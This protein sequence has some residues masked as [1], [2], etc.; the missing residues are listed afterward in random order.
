MRP[1]LLDTGVIVSWL[2]SSES[3]HTRC[4]AILDSLPTPVFTCDAV[5][6]E[7]CY[8]L[9]RLPGACEAILENIAAGVFQ[10]PFR[11]SDSAR[12]VQRIVRKYQDREIDLADACLIHL[13][14]ELK[15]G[16]I[17]TL[18]SDFRVY[19]WANNQAFHLLL[20]G[21]S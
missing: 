7:A 15:T 9:R 17:L 11:L 16:E 5:I 3:F 12:D 19:R 14:N 20:D 4:A 21:E 8:L 6:A 10:M 1:V 18:D 13:A 2:D